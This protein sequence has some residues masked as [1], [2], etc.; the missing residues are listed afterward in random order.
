MRP[1]DPDSKDH[2]KPDPM[3]P[4]SGGGNPKWEAL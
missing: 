2:S 3:T 4:C 1:R